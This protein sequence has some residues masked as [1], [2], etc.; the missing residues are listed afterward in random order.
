MRHI[1]GLDLSMTSFGWFLQDGKNKHTYGSFKTS[2]KDGIDIKRFMMQRDRFT[3]L[4]QETKVDHVGIEQ[5]FLRS[6]NT[7]KLYALHQLVL[8][9]CYK[10]HINVVYITPAQ[11]KTYAVGTPRAGKNEIVFRTREIL[12]L[13]REKI[14]NDECD[15]YFVSVLAEKF[16]K[17]HYKEITEDDLSD[18]EK[19]IIVKTKSNKPGLIKK[20]ND[21]FFIFK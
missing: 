3:N 8:E 19:Y 4:I 21:S 17:L 12:N 11:L 16:W 1:L 20:K 7:E 10:N 6:F 9:V 18:A 2:P 14:N 15:A 5:P 13:K